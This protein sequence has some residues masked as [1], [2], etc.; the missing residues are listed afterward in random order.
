ML[1][2]HEDCEQDQIEERRLCQSEPDVYVICRHEHKE[3]VLA[4]DGLD[5]I[6]VAWHC[7][8]CGRVWPN[9]DYIEGETSNGISGL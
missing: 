4:T 8:C 9:K 3:A 1:P 5:E 7:H 6:A 2:G